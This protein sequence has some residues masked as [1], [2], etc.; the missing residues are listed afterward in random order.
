MTTNDSVW[1]LDLAS[2]QPQWMTDFPRI[3]GT[4][5]FRSVPLMRS[6]SYAF[7]SSLSENRGLTWC[8][9]LVRIRVVLDARQRCCSCHNGTN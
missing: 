4:F 8:S 6:I 3:K 1:A 2:P 9:I 5:I 7:F